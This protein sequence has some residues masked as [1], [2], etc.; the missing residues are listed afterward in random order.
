M[1]ASESLVINRD[2]SAIS[3]KISAWLVGSIG[4]TETPSIPRVTRSSSIRFWSPRPPP[5]NSTVTWQ[6]SSLPAAMA[7]ALAMVQ[8]SATPL[9]T[10]ARCGLTFGAFLNSAMRA[11]CA[12]IKS[13]CGAAAVN[14][15]PSAAKV[16][17]E[18]NFR[19]ICFSLM[20][21]SCDHHQTVTPPL[22]GIST[23]VMNDAASEAR[24]VTAPPISEGTPK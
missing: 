11:F 17:I 2:F 9:E 13:A 5:G 10:N 3:V 15:R 21:C 18:I 22:T 14:A 6:L 4:L 7:P 23:P 12:A 19:F 16:T 20:S 8:K 24:N 1:G